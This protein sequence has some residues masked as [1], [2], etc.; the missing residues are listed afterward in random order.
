[1]W[2]RVPT[3]NILLIYSPGPMRLNLA[4][5]VKVIFSTDFC[6]L[7]DANQHSRGDNVGTLEHF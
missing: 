3:V 4:W 5:S 6:S 7:G 2:L 1:M